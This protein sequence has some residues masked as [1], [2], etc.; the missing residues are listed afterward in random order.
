M[1]CEVDASNVVR[2]LINGGSGETENAASG[3][4]FGTIARPAGSAKLP[5]V[6]IGVWVP[7]DGSTLIS[8]PGPPNAFWSATTIAPFGAVEI[9]RGLFR[10]PPAERI[11]CTP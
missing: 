11:V 6:A 1:S 9:P 8:P 4:W 5:P 7:D 10:L 2:R 3:R